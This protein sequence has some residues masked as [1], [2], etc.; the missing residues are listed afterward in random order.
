LVQFLIERQDY[1]V[2]FREPNAF[3]NS[4]ECLALLVY[5]TRDR[6][7][8]AT[9]DVYKAADSRLSACNLN[10]TVLSE[11]LHQAKAKVLYHHATSTRMYK[12]S[13]LR[14][15]LTD[16]IS[17]FPQN[18]IFLT[19]FAWN[20]SR[21]RIED[22]VRSLLHQHTARTTRSVDTT[23]ANRFGKSSTLIPHIFS[24][25][26]EL[27]RGVSA[28]STAH[29]ARA[30]FETALASH[31]GQSSAGLWKL[32]ILFELALGQ[33]TRARE[34]FH[35]GIRA[36]P[37]VKELVLLAFREPGLRQMMDMQEMRKVWNVLAEK[38]LR[39]HLDLE[40]WFEVHSGEAGIGGWE[41]EKLAMLPVMLPGDGES[42]DDGKQ[43]KYGF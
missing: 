34:V 16:S 36:C 40:E 14:T 26:T 5:I 35:R 3:V 27:H 9:M 8:N 11:R 6:D 18:T 1:G 7:I 41:G 12:P 42:S 39:I 29:S 32:Y 22:R 20:E 23:A 21:F 31:S 2:T 19:L 38:E 33:A 15:E 25:Y 17:L 13:L 37:W 10:K 43:M 4:T 28:G 24:I 30:A